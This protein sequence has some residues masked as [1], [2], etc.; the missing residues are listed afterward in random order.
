M[1]AGWLAGYCESLGGNAPGKKKAA[2][3]IVSGWT[4]PC[5][6]IRYVQTRNALKGLCRQIDTVYKDVSSYCS[7]SN[8]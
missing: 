7:Y 6:C 1:G 2:D 8:L 4:V 3:I 5:F